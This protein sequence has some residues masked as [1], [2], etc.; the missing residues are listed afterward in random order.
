MTTLSGKFKQL[1]AFAGQLASGASLPATAYYALAQVF[2]DLAHSFAWLDHG[3]VGAT[4]QLD[5]SKAATHI[6][7]L[8]QATTINF[9][10]VAEGTYRVIV[11][12]NGAF[13]PT[14]SG[15]IWPSAVAPT[16]TSVAGKADIYEFVSDGARLLGHSLAQNFAW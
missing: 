7:T 1:A 10:N 14:F 8:A 12:Y 11:T 13:A 16:P 2:D 9:A 15:V 4:V 3:T 6:V 5:L